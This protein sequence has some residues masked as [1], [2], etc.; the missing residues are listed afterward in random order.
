MND[1]PDVFPKHPNECPFVDRSFTPQP[2]AHNEPV[3]FTDKAGIYRFY[4][5]FDGFDTTYNAQ[6]CK[7]IGRKRDVFEC[8]NPGEW[9]ECTYYRSGQSEQEPTDV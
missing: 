6:F 9:H 5:H 1:N 2:V 7:L 4:K 3:D 8:L